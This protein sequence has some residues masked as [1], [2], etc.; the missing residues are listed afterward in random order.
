M[1]RAATATDFEDLQRFARRFVSDTPYAKFAGDDLDLT[2]GVLKAP[3]RLVAELD[4]KLIGALLGTANTLWFV[5][6][7]VAVVLAWWVEPEHRGGMAAGRLLEGFEAWA[8][9]QG[10][11]TAFVSDRHIEAP[12]YLQ[13]LGYTAV[14]RQHAKEL[15]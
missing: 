1:I 8:R 13:R 5:P 11:V 6:A 15:M 2:A 14:E 9:E 4:G 7:M 10:C 12:D 3:C